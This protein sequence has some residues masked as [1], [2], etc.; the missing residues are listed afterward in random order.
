MMQK[1]EETG[2][3]EGE[4]MDKALVGVTAGPS[5]RF[6]AAGGT[7]SA[8]SVFSLKSVLGLCTHRAQMLWSRPQP[9]VLCITCL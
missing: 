2:M 9:T 3:E 8:L 7:S 4:G 6:Q 1:E 5:G